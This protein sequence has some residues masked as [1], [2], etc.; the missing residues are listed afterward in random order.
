MMRIG[1]NS[2]IMPMSVGSGGSIHEMT[3]TTEPHERISR[4]PATLA[5]A[6]IR[7]AT[8]RRRE[9]GVMQPNENK[10][11]HGSGRRKWQAVKTD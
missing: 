2:L 8:I 5:A 10:I 9:A 7:N 4:N 1:Q 6:T 3:D 11:S